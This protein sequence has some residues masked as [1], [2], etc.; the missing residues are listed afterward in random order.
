MEFTHF[1]ESDDRSPLSRHPR[2]ASLTSRSPCGRA[3]PRR[4]APT[5]H[6]GHPQADGTT[7]PGREAGS[8]HRGGQRHRL[9]LRHKRRTAEDP[10]IPAT[11]LASPPVVLDGLPPPRNRGGAPRPAT[12]GGGPGEG[13]RQGRRGR[14]GERGKPWGR[15]GR[16][17]GR[18][19]P[20]RGGGPHEHAVARPR[21]TG[22]APAIRDEG[23]QEGIQVEGADE[24]EPVGVVAEEGRPLDPRPITWW[25][26]PCAS[27]RV[28]RSTGGI[29]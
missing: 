24:S 25:R 11:R 19:L 9:L 8:A 10:L 12:R 22:Q 3:P 23:R 5:S 4:G 17:W 18:C 21:K 1:R 16:G 13:R 26:T 27:R 2:A 15:T 29:G 20:S 6:P 28:W 7:D 14:L